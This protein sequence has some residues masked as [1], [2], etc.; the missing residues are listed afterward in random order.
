[1]STVKINQQEL[2]PI[3]LGTWHMGEDP[4][5]KGQ[6]LEA[7]KTGIEH[8]A[9]VLDT[10]EM[11]G[12]GGSELLVGEAL[13]SFNRKDLFLISKVYPW[14]ASKKQL[15]VSLDNS[16]KRLGTDYLDLYLL[17]WTGN[18]PIEETIEAMEEAKKAGKI[19]AWGVSNFDVKDLEKM[20]QKE[21]SQSCQVNQ[22]LYNLGERGI[23]FDL[24]P[25]M[26]EKQLP[27]IAYAP[28]AEGD[29]LGG[30]LTSNAKLKEIAQNHQATVFQMLLAWSIRKGQTLA[31]PQSSNPEHV[32][33]NIEAAQIQLTDEEMKQLDKEFPKPTSKQTLSII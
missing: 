23:E 16:L 9:V 19:K 4:A 13:Q 22:V 15:P 25:F 2:F 20:Y 6:E 26:Q 5:K 28:M 31:I 30:Q 18:V 14:N 3:G 17:H 29:Q 21:N 33:E 11:Y 12:D 1:M 10:A 7:L 24:L 8:G 32:I 27:L